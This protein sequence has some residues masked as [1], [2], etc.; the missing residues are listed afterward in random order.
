MSGGRNVGLAMAIAIMI[1]LPI[2]T[3][4]MNPI[5]QIVGV[6]ASA[7]IGIRVGFDFNANPLKVAIAAV[8][9]VAVLQ[10]SKR[11]SKETFSAEAQCETDSQCDSD[12]F[13]QPEKRLDERIDALLSESQNI[14]D[15]LDNFLRMNVPDERS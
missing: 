3:F 1:A 13:S 14:T 12:I 4:I 9:I 5:G 7:L 10:I 15:D 11:L 2:L 6:W 8:L